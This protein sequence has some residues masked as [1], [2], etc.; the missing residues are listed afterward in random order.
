MFSCPKVY[1][2]IGFAKYLSD[3]FV[4]PCQTWKPTDLFILL[5]YFVLT[6]PV[7]FMPL[8]FD[9]LQQVSEK[10]DFWAGGFPT[11]GLGRRKIFFLVRHTVGKAENFFP[12]SPRRGEGRKNFSSFLIDV[13]YLIGH[14]N[15]K[16]Q[17]LGV[18]NKCSVALCLCVQNALWGQAYFVFIIPSNV[19]LRSV[20]S[21]LSVLYSQYIT[22]RR[23]FSW[24]KSHFRAIERA[25]S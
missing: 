4:L 23:P 13:L 19:A 17:K 8:I 20:P 3:K 7:S 11:L 14:K 5:S 21:A 25:S 24:I 6:S 1:Y 18:K 2:F 15:A 16:A 10:E 22:P 12:R 9:V